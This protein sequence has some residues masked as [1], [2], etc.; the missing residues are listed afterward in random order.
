M[1]VG[2]L[3][4]CS[5]ASS[6]LLSLSLPHSLLRALYLFLALDLSVVLSLSLTIALFLSLFPSLP[7]FYS[8]YCSG[9]PASRKSDSHTHG[10][11]PQLTTSALEKKLR[12]KQ[13]EEHCRRQ[14]WGQIVSGEKDPQYLSFFWIRI[15]RS[16]PHTSFQRH[17]LFSLIAEEDRSARARSL[18]FSLALS[19]DSLLRSSNSA[20]HPLRH[21]PP[22]ATIS[23][24]TPTPC[25]PKRNRWITANCAH[26]SLQLL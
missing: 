14:L 5:R 3:F 26:G 9:P 6:S 10:L 18:S 22:N 19:S 23:P 16:L 12:N 4:E 11:L 1:T 8:G 7:L 24:T 17:P 20:A 15:R 2:C 13:A 25:T 21:P